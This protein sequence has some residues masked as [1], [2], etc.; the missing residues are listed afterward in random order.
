MASAATPLKKSTPSKRLGKPKKKAAYTSSLDP[1]LR[2]L[3]LRSFIAKKLKSEFKTTPFSADAV[4]CMEEA[5]YSVLDSLVSTLSS[6]KKY[7]NTGTLSLRM[8]KAA[9]EANFIGAIRK[10]ALQHGVQ[11]MV[12]YQEMK[13]SKPKNDSS[14]P[15]SGETSTA[16]ASAS[17][18]ASASS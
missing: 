2:N 8:A 15:T 5:A 6:I 9:V 7:H 4:A 18:S 14:A 12:L 11:T 17:A 10:G 1:K 3:R 16:P 13:G